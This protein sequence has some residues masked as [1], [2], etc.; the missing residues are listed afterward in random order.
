MPE[1]IEKYINL[2]KS[3]IG[4]V[5]QEYYHLQ[6]TYEP[7][8]IVRERVFCYE[9]YHQIRS[10]MTPCHKLSLNGEIDKRG[11]KDFECKDWK[12]PDFVFHI[13]G[14]NEHNTIV[15]EVKG[16]LSGYESEIMDD[17]QTLLTFISKYGYTAGIFI[18]Y[19][20]TFDEL[21]KALGRETG[22]MSRESAA[23]DVYIL[24]AK[25][26]NNECE[27]HVLLEM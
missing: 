9:L 3:S 23:R 13:P 12:N 24:C 26:A 25:I 15:I 16:K 22:E 5:G 17:L 1:D 8:G 10:Q 7:S 4:K 19:N 20:H 6:T 21:K 11:H 18:L 2:V 14:T 27:Q